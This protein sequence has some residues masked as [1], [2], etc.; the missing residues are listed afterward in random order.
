[1]A[2][3]S[4]RIFFDPQ[5]ADPGNY[6][7]LLLAS[8]RLC[9]LRQTISII[10][11]FDAFPAWRTLRCEMHVRLFTMDEL[12]S[13]PEKDSGRRRSNQTPRSPPL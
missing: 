1:M 6:L 10:S 5:G 11:V 2:P 4:S 12:K 7:D 13:G 9:N 8:G 3:C